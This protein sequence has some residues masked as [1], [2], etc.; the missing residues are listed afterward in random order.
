MAGDKVESYKE[1]READLLLKKHKAG[2]NITKVHVSQRM[3]AGKGRGE[4]DV[5]SR[6]G[7]LASSAVK[8]GASLRPSEASLVLLC[9]L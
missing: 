6:A 2:D 3:R 4:T 5:M 1:T 9:L 7:N 8:A